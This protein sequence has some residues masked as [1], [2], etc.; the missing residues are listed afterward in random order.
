M[1]TVQVLQWICDNSITTPR[2][3]QNLSP[4]LYHMKHGMWL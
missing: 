4:L 3:N 1:K 2:T